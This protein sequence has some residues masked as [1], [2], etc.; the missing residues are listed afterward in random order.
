MNDELDLDTKKAPRW[1]SSPILW[2]SG[3]AVTLEHL[4]S[5]QIGPFTSMPHQFSFMPLSCRKHEPDWRLLLLLQ[6]AHR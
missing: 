3:L 6:P 2:G 5:V 4:E 1:T